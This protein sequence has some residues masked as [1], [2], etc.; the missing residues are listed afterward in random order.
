MEVLFN[1]GLPEEADFLS[2][3]FLFFSFFLINI[4]LHGRHETFEPKST[5]KMK[6]SFQQPSVLAHT[7]EGSELFWS[8]LDFHENEIKCDSY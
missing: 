8:G 2:F 1:C 4:S 7:D 5:L 6:L 3:S